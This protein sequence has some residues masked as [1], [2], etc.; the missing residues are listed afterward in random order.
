M[1]ESAYPVIKL[2]EERSKFFCPAKWTELYLYLNHG[3]SNS[4]HHPIPHRIPAELLDD[5]SVL[6]NTPHKLKMQQLMIDGH[7][8]DECHM[9]WHIEDLDP[10][11]VSD[12][13]HKSQQWIADIPS[14]EVNTQYV[15]KF[16]EVVF[17]NT[18]NL[19]CSYCDSGQS[20][21][22]AN[23]ITSE[24]L[25][26]KTDYRKLYHKLSLDNPN[27]NQ[28]FDAW[29]RWWPSILDRV[30]TIK[31]SGGEPLISKRCWQFI[32]S[33][34]NAK[35]LALNVNSN[36]TYNTSV[37]ERLAVVSR[38][39]KSLHISASIDARGDIAEYTRQ[40]L[41]YQQFINNIEY[42]CIHTPDNCTISIQATVNILSVWGFT[43][44]F[45]LVIMLRERFPNKVLGAY[46]TLVRFPEFQSVSVL[47]AEL[48]LNLANFIDKW[49]ID[50]VTLLTSKEQDYINRTVIYLRSEP[51]SLK[52][53]PLKNLLFDFKKYI[54]YYDRTSSKKLSQIYP[55]EF[56]NWVNSLN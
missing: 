19:M 18:C 54:E 46:S 56:V 51:E 40:N 34:D 4:C 1:T 55:V 10:N 52:D 6:H 3:N 11:A 43:D 47:P 44:L 22:W 2:L 27:D 38:K 53:L 14:L 42:W 13:I 20:S 17:D 24:K 33:T 35:N 26:L 32:E 12:R 30:E 5:P 16:I 41:N 23:K 36:L 7:R 21:T 45:D 48:R 25:L 39:F 8:P 29:M 37:L 31:I 49:L 9:C 28:Y 15:P 50:R